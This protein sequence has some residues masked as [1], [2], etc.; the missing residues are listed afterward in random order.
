MNQT[1]EAMA[2]A[3]FKEWFVLDAK[4][5]WQLIELGQLIEIKGGDKYASC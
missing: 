5:D 2:Q 4:E 1:L 3:I